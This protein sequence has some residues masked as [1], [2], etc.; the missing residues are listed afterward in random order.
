MNQLPTQQ[1]RYRRSGSVPVQLTVLQQLETEYASDCAEIPPGPYVPPPVGATE[2]KGSRKEAQWCDMQ[3]QTSSN[4]EVQSM[5]DGDASELCK[6]NQIRQTAM[7]QPLSTNLAMLEIQGSFKFAPG[8]PMIQFPS[9][10]LLQGNH[11][12]TAGV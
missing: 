4:R 5:A 12:S 6:S 2:H 7:N 8:F 9:Q 10:L 11:S 1:I 3:S